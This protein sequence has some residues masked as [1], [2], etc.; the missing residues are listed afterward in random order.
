MRVEDQIRD[1]LLLCPRN[2]A[3]LF[4]GL[5][6]NKVAIRVKWLLE[7]AW[8]EANFQSEFTCLIRA[9]PL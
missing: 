3:A 9:I 7:S 4:S 6:V 8:A 1:Q 5:A 2:R